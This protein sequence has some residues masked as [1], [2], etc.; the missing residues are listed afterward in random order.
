MARNAGVNRR[1]L[2]FCR[3]ERCRYRI[4]LRRLELLAA[5]ATPAADRRPRYDTKTGRLYVGKVFIRRFHTRGK[6]HLIL[7][8]FQ[9]LGWPPSIEA[10]PECEPLL[11]ENRLRDVVHLMNED[12]LCPLIHFF[13][14]GTGEGVCWCFLARPA[15]SGGGGGP[16]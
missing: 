2:R 4:E 14:D 6:Q 7:A 15:L 1:S 12:H 9:R 5:A 3:G 10:P 13:C 8:E 16:R 11:V